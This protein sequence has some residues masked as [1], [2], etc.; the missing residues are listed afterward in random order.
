M[1]KIFID[2]HNANSKSKINS[3]FSSKKASSIRKKDAL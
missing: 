2:A 1:K 3:M